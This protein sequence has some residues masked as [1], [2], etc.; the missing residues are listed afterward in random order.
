MKPT[1]CYRCS[2]PA[3]PGTMRCTECGS[4]AFIRGPKPQWPPEYVVPSQTR[5]EK[6]ADREMVASLAYVL[7]PMPHTDAGMFGVFDDERGQRVA[8]RR[9]PRVAG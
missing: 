3:Q 8:R 9:T 4:A 5:D 2:E 7:G 1:T 6:N